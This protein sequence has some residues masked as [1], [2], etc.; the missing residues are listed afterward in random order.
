VSSGLTPD[1]LFDTYPLHDGEIG[2]NHFDFIPIARELLRPGGVLTYY[3]DETEEF[4]TEHLKLIFKSFLKV[5]L[6]KVEGL[7]PGEACNYWSMDHM[8]IPVMRNEA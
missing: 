6:C 8:V 1:F 5:E 4:R 7:Q 3:S 2:R